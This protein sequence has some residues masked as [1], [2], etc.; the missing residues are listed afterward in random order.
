MIDDVRQFLTMI[1]RELRQFAFPGETVN[2]FLVGRSAP[3]LGRD[4]RPSTRDA[5]GPRNRG[6]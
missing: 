6:R 5:E 1:D 2:L 3:V 4:A